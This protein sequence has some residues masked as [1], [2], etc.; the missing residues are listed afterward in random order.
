MQ[1]NTL[2]VSA[3]VAVVLVVALL[4]LNGEIGPKVRGTSNFDT[5]SVTGLQV[6]TSGTTLTNSLTSTCTLVANA[7][8][9]ATSTGLAYCAASGVNA[10]DSVSVTLATTTTNL[11]SQILVIGAMATTSDVI[12]VRLLN[13]TGAAITPGSVS[14]FGSSTQYRATR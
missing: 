13:L 4:S 9:A 3:I 11:N 14:G 12:G 1:K 8:I 5:I 10:G 6:G 7:S 2:V